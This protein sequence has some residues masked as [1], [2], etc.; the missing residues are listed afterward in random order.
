MLI[1][2]EQGREEPVPAG[3]RWSQRRG[4]RLQTN[5]VKEKYVVPSLILKRREVVRRDHQR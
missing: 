1:G 4:R 3:Y 5:K 2:R